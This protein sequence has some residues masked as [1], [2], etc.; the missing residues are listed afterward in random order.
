MVR[1][2]EALPSWMSNGVVKQKTATAH[3]ATN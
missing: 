1:F 3:K 2:C